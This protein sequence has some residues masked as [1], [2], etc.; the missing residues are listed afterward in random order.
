MVSEL[1]HDLKARSP[2]HSGKGLTLGP[3]YTEAAGAAPNLGLIVTQRHHL[4][5]LLLE[6]VE[7]LTGGAMSTESSSIGSLIFFTVDR[8]EPLRLRTGLDD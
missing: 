8:V 6:R 4:H 1:I 7:R 3:Y 2:P 5:C